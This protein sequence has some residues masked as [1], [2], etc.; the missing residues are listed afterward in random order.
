MGLV[1]VSFYSQMILGSPW[2]CN[3]RIP[4]AFFISSTQSA[5]L[6]KD[7]QAQ[8]ENLSWSAFSPFTALN[9]EYRVEKLAYSSP[10]PAHS[11]LPHFLQKPIN[12]P[13]RNHVRFIA[14]W[15]VLSAQGHP[16]QGNL[17]SQRAQLEIALFLRFCFQLPP[18][19]FR[20]PVS[21]SA[22]CP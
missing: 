21:C 10:P 13:H 22:L 17:M 20:P 1:F 12:E 18:I 9:R 5:L 16:S 6:R 7:F 14:E 2:S 8:R 19:C 11:V 3:T 15:Q 4:S